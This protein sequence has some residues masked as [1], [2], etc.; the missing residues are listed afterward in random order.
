MKYQNEA[1][2]PKLITVRE[3]GSNS[4]ISK[5]CKALIELIAE[6]KIPFTQLEK[7]A[8]WEN[9]IHT[10]NPGFVIPMKDQ[11]RKLFIEHSQNA[12]EKGLND[13]RGYTCGLAV[14]G[15]T[16]ISLNNYVFVLVFKDGLSSR[17]Y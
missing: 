16:L 13:L 8:P 6:Q 3:N 11:L 17:K 12:T 10:L 14:D 5:K 1:V 9:F 7:G 4:S 2:E 15:E